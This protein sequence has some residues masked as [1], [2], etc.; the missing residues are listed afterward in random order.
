MSGSIEERNS[1]ENAKSKSKRLQEKLTDYSSSFTIHGLSRTIHTD[2]HIERLFWIISLITAVSMALFLVRTL[3]SK[4]WD[5]EV[6]WSSEMKSAPQN[7]FP[8]VT[9][10]LDKMKWSNTFCQIPVDDGRQLI[11]DSKE[12]TCHNQSGWWTVPKALDKDN[13]LDEIDGKISTKYFTVSCS[14]DSRSSECNSKDMIKKYFKLAHEDNQCLTWN[15]NGTFANAKNRVELTF[16][17]LEEHDT[18]KPYVVYIHDHEESPLTMDDW[19][20]ISTAFDT[21]IILKKTI[22]N[23]Q[24]RPPPNS[25]ENQ[26]YNN[27]KNIFPGRYTV[28]ACQETFTCKEALKLCGEVLDYCEGYLPHDLIEEHWIANSSL[29]E[30][31]QCMLDNFEDGV[32][33]APTG[34]CIPPCKATY[35]GFQTIISS[36]GYN[37]LALKYSDRNTYQLREEKLVY[38]W[39]DFLSGT[40]G[41]IGL[42]CGFSILSLAELLV[43]LVLKL[44]T[45]CLKKRICNEKHE[46]TSRSHKTSSN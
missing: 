23:R 27:S 24:Q 30:I 10:C 41:M 28:E 14:F 18:N 40:G 6:Y 11:F 16:E 39:E 12:K 37:I 15:Y 46:P 34:H 31:Q 20:P 8:A 33:F 17:I 4:Y 1:Q 7:T 21:Q 36:P 5:K 29:S 3:M 9:F 22:Q 26:Y 19:I 43:Y 32:F 2:S 38:T 45:F 25:C 44:T 13:F 35:Y 42:F